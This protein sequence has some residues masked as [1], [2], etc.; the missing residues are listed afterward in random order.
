MR[1]DLDPVGVILAGGQGRRIGGSKAIV[2]LRGRPLI[3]YPLAALSGALADVAIVAKADTALPSLAGVTVWIEPE[4]PQ[5]PAVGIVQALALAAG[6]P[7]LVCGVD[8][9]FVTSELIGT[10]ACTDPLDAPAVV[11]TSGGALQPL[12][13]LYL[14]AAMAL[15]GRGARRDHSPLREQVAAIGPRLI[16]VDDPNA[17]FNINAPEDLLRAAALMDRH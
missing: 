12:L 5:H 16:E 17:F 3:T 1:R 7:V 14:P 6:R 9:P 2:E 13:A 10:I 11:P 8:M 15:L 4:T